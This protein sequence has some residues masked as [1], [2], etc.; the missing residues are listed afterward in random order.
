MTDFFT[1]VGS[2]LVYFGEQRNAKY[3]LHFARLLTQSNY[4]PMR[5]P[6]SLDGFELQ[7]SVRLSFKGSASE[8]S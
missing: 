6:D 7:Y 5:D 4:P 3:E 1:S 2:T 8:K